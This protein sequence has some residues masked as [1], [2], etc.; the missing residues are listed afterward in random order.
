MNHSLGKI[1]RPSNTGM[2]GLAMD[3]GT[4]LLPV[5]VE[6]GVV[7]TTPFAVWHPFDVLHAV[8]HYSAEQF[9]TSF[10]GATSVRSVMPSPPC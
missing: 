4:I 3:L 5:E 2:D 1:V 8:Y 6:P 7:R 10:L 9:R